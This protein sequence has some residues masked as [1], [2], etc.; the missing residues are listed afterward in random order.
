MA[1]RHR[2]QVADQVEAPVVE[3]EVEVA[4]DLAG[5]GGQGGAVRMAT[6]LGR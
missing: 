1:V 5:W 2:P 6:I 3:M 4:M